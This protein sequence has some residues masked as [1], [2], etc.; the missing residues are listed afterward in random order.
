[1]P[2]PDGG[3]SFRASGVLIADHLVL[4]WAHMFRYAEKAWGHCTLTPHAHG[5]CRG[6]TTRISVLVNSPPTVNNR[7]APASAATFSFARWA[8][9]DGGETLEAEVVDADRRAAAYC[10]PLATGAA[11]VCIVFL[12]SL[13][14]SGPRGRATRDRVTFTPHET[15]G[16]TTYVRACVR[17]WM[18]LRCAS[19][20]RVLHRVRVNVSAISCPTVT[21][22]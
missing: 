7:K 5:V 8:A 1:M 21:R 4:T 15:D 10:K 9:P 16:T 2:N 14:R 11:D 17:G 12:P 6:H 3:I 19:T 22:S 18:C 20:A 13:T